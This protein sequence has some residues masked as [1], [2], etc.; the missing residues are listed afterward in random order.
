MITCSLCH[1]QAE[2]DDVALTLAAGR[3]ICLRCYRRE[4]GTIQP[5]P[6][7]LRRQLQAALAAAA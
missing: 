5:M 2:L 7:A 4:T 3:S 1:F 6:T